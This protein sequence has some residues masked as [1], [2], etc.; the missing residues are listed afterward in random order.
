M[1][2]DYYEVL[3][4]DRDADEATIKKSF[5]RLARELHPDVNAHD[6][7]AEEKF[8]EAAEAYEVLSD[9]E[10]RADLRRLRPRGPE[11]RRVLAQLRG[12]RVDL[13]TSSAP[14]SGRAAASTP[15]SAARGCAAGP[16]RAA[17]SR[18][19]SRS[20]W[21]RPRAALGRGLLR[22]DGPVRDLPRQRRRPPR[23]RPARRR[24]AGVGRGARRP[25]TRGGLRQ[26]QR[27]PGPRA[28]RDRHLVRP[29]R[30][31]RPDRAGASGREGRRPQPAG[32][33]RGPEG[34]EGPAAGYGPR[35]RA[36]QGAV[37]GRCARAARGPQAPGGP[38]HRPRRQP[39]RA[40]DLRSGPRRHRGCP[41]TAA[42]PRPRMG[43]AGFPAGS[44]C[45]RIS[46]NGSVG[47]GAR[48]GARHCPSASSAA[49]VFSTPSS[50][51]Y[52]PTAAEAAARGALNAVTDAPPIEVRG[53]VKHYGDLVAVGGIGSSQSLARR[54]L[55]L[56][57]APTA[58][59][60]PPR[61]G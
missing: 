59:A 11:V 22:R 55:R 52:R 14:S 5:R 37:Q 26:R 1:P 2:R 7:E 57:R 3:G 29:R 18:W 60:R 41:R 33:Q 17:T 61:C 45:R 16:C 50:A 15:P 12:L 4:V 39:G 56:S 13:A 6:P 54:R 38:A 8:K 25:A 40:R 58:R 48:H 34:H 20:R 35:R 23:R 19:R 47:R 9:A 46:I 42:E 30:A 36:G 51:R 27:Q 53:L 49:G 32:E 43:T 21:G 10:R 44:A 28:A 24:R 31:R